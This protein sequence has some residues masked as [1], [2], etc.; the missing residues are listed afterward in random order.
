MSLLVLA[1]PAASNAAYSG[2]EGKIAFEGVPTGSGTD[3]EIVTSN[4]DGTA[5]TA[6]TSNSVND[7][8]P[9]WSPDG[10]KI[11]FARFN[12]SYYEIWT[13]NA[14]GSGQTVVVQQG[15]STTH[16]AW[17]PAGNKLLFTLAFSA[18]DDD[19]YAAD[20]TGL[21]AN[22]V[23]VATSGLH[24]RDAAWQ[25]GSGNNVVFQRFNSTNS[26]YDLVYKTYPSGSVFPLLSSTVTDYSEPAW[27][28]DGTRVAFRNGIGANPDIGRI[29]F[30]GT[31][32]VGSLPGSSTANDFN[33][34]WSP[35]G[36]LLVY[37]N[38]T[39]SSGTDSDLITH[40]YDGSL[41]NF[42]ANPG[43]DRDPDWQPVTTAQV[44]P[45]STQPLVLPL[46]IAF[47]DCGSGP[48]HDPPF[49]SSTCGPAD[50]SSPDLTVGEPLVNGKPAK[51]SGTI[52]I[53]TVSPSNGAIAVSIKDVR[54]KNYFSGCNVILGDYTSFVN[55]NMQFQITDRATAAGTAA[56]IPTV[57][58]ST[59]V[60]C[61]ATSDT[62][63]GSS[64]AVNTDLNTIVP[65]AVVP[66]KR[67]SWVLLDASIYDT[68]SHK[69][70]VPG[71]F[72][73]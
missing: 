65:G 7:I 57:S 61:T 56:T 2:E 49:N 51:G 55:L 20:S 5:T 41:R 63:V 68:S 44:R 70:M 29:N 18:S 58:L 62:T 31:G 64:C 6:L 34:A 30:N 46:T 54:C 17:S 27:S 25:P 16:P 10:K 37:E 11:A 67:A 71:N 52:K 9:A 45:Q 53:Q 24:E 8:D 73:P 50:A 13:M 26:R 59:N 21:N 35:E 14:D 4:A 28:P 47:D 43:H 23:S 38:E 33:P 19:I 48:T 3:S 40:R 36:Q 66:G 42:N 39:G 15:K 69:F 12:G 32:Y 72:Y 60:P 22:L 1:L